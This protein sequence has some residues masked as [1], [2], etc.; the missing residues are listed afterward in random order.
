MVRFNIYRDDCSSPANGFDMGDIEF[1]FEKEILSSRE[2][3]R[4]K[5]MV[6]LSLV[7][8]VDGLLQL[9]SA[10]RYEFVATDSSFTLQF[11]KNKNGIHVLHKKKQY[12][13]IP[14][15]DL[16]KAINFGIEAFISDRRNELPKNDSVYSDFNSAK[17][18]LKG[19]LDGE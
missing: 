16:L 3:S 18:A 19:A 12:G 8:L 10:K 6:F 2:N 5:S 13:P 14:L 15:N 4:F 7:D 11:E 17:Q 9:R 1:T